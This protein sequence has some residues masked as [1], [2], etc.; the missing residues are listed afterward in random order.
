MYKDIESRTALSLA[1]EH[2]Q[3]NVVKLLLKVK[4]DVD[5]NDDNYSQ[6]PLSWAAESG[7]EGDR[8]SEFSLA[9]RENN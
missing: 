6:M 7:H 4:A 5:S 9:K 8:M 3:E 1:A 2:G